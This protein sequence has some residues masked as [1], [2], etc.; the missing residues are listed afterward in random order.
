M[1]TTKQGGGKR[2][3]LTT[4]IVQQPVTV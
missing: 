4:D 1:T 2:R 3:E